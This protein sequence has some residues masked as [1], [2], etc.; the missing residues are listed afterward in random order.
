[1]IARTAP[2]TVTSGLRLA[3]RRMSARL[4]EIRLARQMAAE[5]HHLNYHW[6]Q[7]KETDFIGTRAIL[8]QLPKEDL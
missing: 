3:A 5:L 4:T 7:L 6:D 1:M 8:A 2:L